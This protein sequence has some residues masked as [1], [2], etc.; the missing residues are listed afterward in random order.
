[1]APTDL[2]LLHQ[3]PGHDTALAGGQVER[4]AVAREERSAR[5]RDH[6][7]PE[8]SRREK[9]AFDPRHRD[10]TAERLA[11]IERAVERRN[12]A[13]PAHLDRALAARR[14]QRPVAAPTPLD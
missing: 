11:M 8:A 2:L 3:P 10:R 12:R 1:M 6:R 5:P 13:V 14:L 4:H 7:V 9:S